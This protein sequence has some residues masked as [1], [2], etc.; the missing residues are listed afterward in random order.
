[1]T[2]DSRVCPC[3]CFVFKLTREP[4]VHLG[5]KIN[6]FTCCSLSLPLH[7][8]SSETIMKCDRNIH[9][10][11]LEIFSFPLSEHV[12]EQYFESNK[13]SLGPLSVLPQHVDIRVFPD[14][15]HAQIREPPFTGRD[16]LLIE[17]QIVDQGPPFSY[18]ISKRNTYI[19]ISYITHMRVQTTRRQNK[20]LNNDEPMSRLVYKLSWLAV[21]IQVIRRLPRCTIK[22]ILRRSILVETKIDEVLSRFP[23]SSLSTEIE[24]RQVGERVESRR[25][26]GSSLSQFT[27]GSA[28]SSSMN[29]IY[30]RGIR[31]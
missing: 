26:R 14:F 20:S 16:W 27:G 25:T 3:F 18:N 10:S 15:P 29:S 1:M 11:D 22:F 17:L 12:P 6:P 30:S 4:A 21:A 5:K 23:F 7:N 19:P 28:C 13:T 9:P 31:E 24:N 8:C 2:G